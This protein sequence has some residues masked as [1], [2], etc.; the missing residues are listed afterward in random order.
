MFLNPKR[1]FK[2]MNKQISSSIFDP[3]FTVQLK[4]TDLLQFLHFY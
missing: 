2:Y 1:Q 3:L 4:I